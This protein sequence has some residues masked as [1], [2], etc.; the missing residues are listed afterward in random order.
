MARLMVS[1]SNFLLMDEP[2]NHIDMPTREI[3]E[4]ALAA[5]EGT[6]LFISH[7][8]Y[9]LNKVAN[10]IFELTPHGIEISLGNYDDYARSKLSQAQ[11]DALEW[12]KNRPSVNKTQQKQ[13]RKRAKAEEAALRKQKK[14]L[15]AL[16]ATMENN[17]EQIA[18]Y[19]AQMCES[20][21]YDN[22]EESQKITEAY[23]ALKAANDKN[24]EEWETLALALESN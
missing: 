6:L 9:F 24:M 22:L 19:E 12:E 4:D 7:D 16:E 3:L 5:Y 11:R 17:D 21:F 14:A 8:R 15:K 10:T 18:K 1:E 20:N 23:N 13:E 2:T